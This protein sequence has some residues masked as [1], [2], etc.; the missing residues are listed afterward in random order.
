MTIYAKSNPIETLDEHTHRMLILWDKLKQA[1]PGLF[2]EHGWQMLRYAIEIHDFGKAYEGFQYVIQSAIKKR[3]PSFEMTDGLSP[4]AKIPHNCLS[5]AAMDVDMLKKAGWTDDDVDIVASAVYFHHERNSINEKLAACITP[6]KD[7]IRTAVGGS[8][9]RLIKERFGIDPQKI[10]CGAKQRVFRM[11]PSKRA[12]SRDY[13]LLHGWLNRIDY[14]AS[15]HLDEIEIPVCDKN[16]FTYAALTRSS[17][18]A[19]PRMRAVQE[20]ALENAGKNL[21]FVAATGS[22]KTE[23]ALLWGADQKLFYTLPVRTAIN[24][25]YERIKRKLGYDEAALLHS[26]A[27]SV[28]MDND[29]DTENAF[30]S[31]TAARQLS[32]PLTVCTVDQLFSFIF[33]G[34]GFELKLA[35]LMNALVVIDEIQS[36]SPDVIAALIHGLRILKRYGGR[37]LIMTATLPKI[38]ARKAI[39]PL[40]DDGSG[41]EPSIPHFHTE[42]DH[43]HRVELRL[44]ANWSEEALLRE[45]I[46]QGEN[47]RVLITVN[48][49]KSA[50]ELYGKLKEYEPAYLRLLHSRFIRSDRSLLEQDIIDFAPNDSGRAPACGIWVATQVVEASLDVDFDL[51][52]TDMCAIESLL[53]RMGRVFRSRNNDTESVNVVVLDTQNGVPHVISRHLYRY[54]LNAL[55]ELTGGGAR[56]ILLWESD[57]QDDKARLMDLVYDPALNGDIESSYYQEIKAKLRILEDGFS[58]PHGSSERIDFR[59][60]DSTTVMPYKLCCLLQEEGRFKSWEERLCCSGS[61]ERKRIYNEIYSYTVSVPGRRGLG[62]SPNAFLARVCPDVSITYDCYDPEYGLVSGSEKT[63]GIDVDDRMI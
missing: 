2:T 9:G 49:V 8:Y 23:A 4:L 57:L 41:T 20:Y 29:E 47:K 22:G 34:P 1:L 7:E 36:Y 39:L 60:I 14:A 12:L 26:D 43:R 13:I 19:F 40:L 59:E 63:G 38:I 42:L 50:Q 32:A 31:Y 30:H 10:Y 61:A 28:Y 6:Y 56:P 33:L 25:M 48:T 44:K 3:D 46:A 37:F 54:S 27:L 21:A 62:R 11:D 45:I 51:L 24:A 5:P 16:G 18:D 15:A 17:L 55:C 53:Q 58:M 52:Y 35:T